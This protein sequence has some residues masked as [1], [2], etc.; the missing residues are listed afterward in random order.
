MT[1]GPLGEASTNDDG[2]STLVFRRTFPDPIEDVW[3][4]LTESDRLARWYGHYQG[5]GKP[6][7]T[8]ELTI[9]GEVDAGGEEGDPVTVS[10]LECAPPHRLVVEMDAWHL[11]A[12]LTEEPGGT[13]LV[14][15]QRIPAGFP[16]PVSEVEPG[17]RWYLDRLVA[18]VAGR[19]MPA[20]GPYA[21]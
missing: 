2:T 11:A 21:P 16:Y 6:G 4:T 20:W 7:G 1:T 14:F 12:T 3:A 9:T 10:I 17:W 8:V 13:T 19:P 15:E 18:A 5:T